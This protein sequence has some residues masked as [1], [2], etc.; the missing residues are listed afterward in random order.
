MSKIKVFNTVTFS[1][2][3]A[4]L[5]RCMYVA[6]WSTIAYDAEGFFFFGITSPKLDV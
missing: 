2:P 3:K 1:L 5:Q 6:G 4:Y